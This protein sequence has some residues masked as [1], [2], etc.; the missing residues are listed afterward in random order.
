MARK[1]TKKEE[2]NTIPP[3]T[4]SLLAEDALKIASGNMFENEEAIL[5]SAAVF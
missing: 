4:A 3:C 2:V 5:A 1:K